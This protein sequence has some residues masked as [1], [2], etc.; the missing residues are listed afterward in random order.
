MEARSPRS[1]CQQGWFL[2]RTLFLAYR[3]PLCVLTWWELGVGK[4]VQ[5]LASILIRA[6]IPS[7]RTP[8]LNLIISQRPISKYKHI[9][10]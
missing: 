2:V 4:R 6:L 9:G 5:P 7:W 10:D 1:M 3:W 8:H